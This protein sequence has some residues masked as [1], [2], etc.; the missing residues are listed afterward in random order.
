MRNAKSQMTNDKRQMT[1]VNEQ[2]LP[3]CMTRD[4]LT[5][6]YWPNL[7]LAGMAAVVTLGAIFLLA[8]FHRLNDHDLRLPW[9]REVHRWFGNEGLVFTHA[10]LATLAAGVVLMVAYC[11][12]RSAIRAWLAQQRPDSMRMVL[13][14]GFLFMIALISPPTYSVVSGRARG[15]GLIYASDTPL[16]VA[17][18][19]VRRNLSGN[20]AAPKNWADFLVWKTDGRVRPLAYS[21]EQDYQS[22]FRGEPAWLDEL[23]SYSA[24]YVLVSRQ[25]HPALAKQVLTDDRGGTGKLRI[26][27]QDQRCLLAEI[28]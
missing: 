23:H 19:I 10:L 24:Q 11:C 15:E 5:S 22:I 7:R 21:H 16:Y 27:Y 6:P 3:E 18:E 14:I 17:D 28:L 2:S 26:I 12:V 4:R 20:F 13:A 9:S 8:S 25:E 1:P